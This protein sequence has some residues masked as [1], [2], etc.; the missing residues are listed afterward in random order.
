[1]IKI[2]LPP[3]A[4]EIIDRL[5]AR[6]YE[7][8]AVGGCVR[9]SILGRQPQD[10]DITTSAAPHE[11]KAVFSHTIDTGIAHGTVTVMLGR[12]G[13][14]VTTYRIDG[15]YEDA[16]HPK[17]V[18]FTPNL[19]EDLKRRDF[20]VN[21]M[22]YNE[23]KGLVDAFD[24]IGDLKRGVIRCVGNAKARF[25]E[26]ALRMLRA[27]RFAAQ[28]GFAV[29]EETAEAMRAL[30]GNIAKV[31]AER[32][33]TELVKLLLS[34]HPEELRLAYETG[35]TGVFLPEFDRMMET[36]QNHPH[37]CH[38]VGE[39]TIS[40]VANIRADRV[41]RLSM[42]FHDIAKPKCRTTDENGT[43]HFRG[44][45]QAGSEMTRQ[46]LRRL[47]FD[48]DTTD[49]VCRLV[50]WHDDRPELSEKSVRRAVSRIGLGQYPALFEVKRADI[51]AQSDYMRPE[52]LAYV[53]A[54]E[55]I[56]CEIRERQQCLC[57]KD[58]AVT[59]RDLIESA[60]MKPGP[61]LGAVLEEL[62]EAVLEE[63]EKN[64]RET[65]LALAKK[66]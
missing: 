58:L 37:H 14:E 21:A 12:E 30:A 63:P 25:T 66:S 43:D 29:E 64:T 53:D 39:H 62:L 26:D 13:F 47:K 20:T 11:V 31:S 57:L 19:L 40:A 18:R 34:P 41:L 50:R 36:P 9:D 22:A 42:L 10:W 24:G 49:R 3:K 48:N 60:G 1:M 15:E 46:I 4:A 33:Q 5:E 16:R 38:T 51:L 8:Y 27:V 2:S 61:G 17:E 7:A 28:L 23:T 44:H 45:Q 52:K 65:L 35:L 55:R 56:Y 32:I 54:Y 6:G 59:G